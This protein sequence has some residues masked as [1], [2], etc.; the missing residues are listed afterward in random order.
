MIGRIARDCAIGATVLVGC[1]IF[2]NIAGNNPKLKV[3]KDNV[4]ETGQ[5]FAADCAQV[6]RSVVDLFRR[7]E[8]CAEGE[9][10]D[11]QAGPV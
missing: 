9:P 5:D 7:D 6:G 4:K 10:A 3:V 1:R 2:S 8:A 11:C